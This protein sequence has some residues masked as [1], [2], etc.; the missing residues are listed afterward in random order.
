MSRDF[1]AAA[2]VAEA[3]DKVNWLY[4]RGNSV[5][6]RRL[7]LAWAYTAMGDAAKAKA[8]YTDIHTKL[9]NCGEGATGR[10]G[11]LTW[12][13]GLLQ[14][15]SGSRTR[16]SLKDVVRSSC[17]RLSRDAF[18]GPEYL[19]YLAQLYVSVGENAQAIDLLQQTMSIP[20]GLSMSSA[21]LKLD[22]TWDP[23]RAD[24]RFD[25]LLKQNDS[26]TPHG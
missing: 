13:W 25:A 4:S 1:A 6:P 26:A 19:V 20:A 5:L 18:A 23:L 12:P 24:P 3:S 10:L 8:L 22:P 17:C 7:R 14:P 16:P 2:R 11:S 21:L 9:S 15:V